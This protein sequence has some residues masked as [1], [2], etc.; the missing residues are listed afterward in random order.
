MWVV[1]V[2]F[3][4]SSSPFKLRAATPAYPP[5]PYVGSVIP[6]AVLGFRS[7]GV[8]QT[9]GCGR[10]F[11]VSGRWLVQVIK[12]EKK[13]RDGENK[14]YKIGDYCLTLPHTKTP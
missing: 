11:P 7:L 14:R 1:A 12:T 10:H 3:G 5:L 6:A 4:A 8:A 9:G 2:F 13:N